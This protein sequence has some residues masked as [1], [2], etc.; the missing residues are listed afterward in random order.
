YGRGTQDMKG[1]DAIT[2]TTLLRLHAEGYKPARDLIVAF[3]A[4]EEG[5][6][7]NG[8]DWLL[9][10]HRDLVD[11]EYV[12]NPD[13]GGPVLHD[14]KPYLIDLSASE[15]AYGDYRVT[16]TNP[17]GHSSLP[18]P[19]NA[20]YEVTDALA[21]LQHYTFPL[22]LNPVTRAHFEQ[23]AKLETGQRAADMR[24]LLQTPP[25]RAAA[26]RLSQDPNLNSIL[27]TTCVT[28]RLQAGHANNALPQTA[29]ANVNCRIFPGHTREQIRQEL[30]RIFNDPKLKVEYIADN[31]DAAPKA[32]DAGAQA[33]PPVRP[34]L[35]QAAQ[36][37]SRR[38][39]N[40][41]PVVPEMEAGASDN[42]YTTAAG[43]PSYQM[44]PVAVDE[45]D[46]RA[47]GKDERIRITAFNTGVDFY[48]FLLK[49]LTGGR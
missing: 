11:G 26:E 34:D 5:G 23:M 35:L 15:K 1:A 45:D 16:A 36:E 18:R 4:D 12:L 8:V 17:G 39:F 24:A 6:K 43:I 30:I 41:A 47:H 28:T 9:K 44:G 10:N 42:I 33:P 29:V 38:F 37:G 3:T 14:G 19:D 2:A 13:G 27:R 25:N 46:V 48:Y 20:I 49:A 40:G 32:P 31:G 7:S 22:E 21:K